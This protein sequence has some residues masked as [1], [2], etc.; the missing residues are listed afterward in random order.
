MSK[1]IDAYDDTS[2]GLGDNGQNT[3]IDLTKGGMEGIIPT[4]G[5]ENQDGSLGDGWVSSHPYIS[6]DLIPI[7]L[8]VPGGYDFMP[9][10]ERWK[11]TWAALF[12]E[13]AISI[14]GLNNGINIEVDETEIAG[15]GQF[16]EATRDVKYIRATLS[17]EHKE[18]DLKSIKKF[19][20]NTVRYLDKDPIAKRPLASD[21]ISDL[22]EVGGSWTPDLKTGSILF[23]EPDVTRKMAVNVFYGT[24]IGI[25]GNIDNIGKKQLAAGGESDTFTIE[26]TIISITTSKVWDLANKL[27]PEFLS[28]AATL[29]ADIQLTADKI[30]SAE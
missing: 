12:T 11:K 23:V 10:P 6:Q 4:I 16:Q 27:L 24:N 17:T 13:H 9:E 1:I 21:F 19:L 20:I 28:T 22:N 7:I 14:Q 29:P 30:E 5:T 26:W 25:K 2:L 8:K 18:K 15:T 3:V